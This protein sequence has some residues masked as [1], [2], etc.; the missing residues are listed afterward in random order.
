MT[1]TI[2][3]PCA[4]RT[5]A[6][7]IAIRAHPGGEDPLSVKAADKNLEDDLI[8]MANAVLIAATVAMQHRARLW[9]QVLPN[10]KLHPAMVVR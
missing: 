7:V 3:A 6:R 10:V 5:V 8:E 9:E 2:A 4:G 1:L